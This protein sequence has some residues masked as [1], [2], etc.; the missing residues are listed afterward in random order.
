MIITILIRL[1]DKVKENCANW[2]LRCLI[3]NFIPVGL[4]DFVSLSRINNLII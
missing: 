2:H 1:L 4:S 3:K